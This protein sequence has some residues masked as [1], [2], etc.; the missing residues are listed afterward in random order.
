MTIY[1][2]LCDHEEDARCRLI[3]S[4]SW[5]VRHLPELGISEAAK[6]EELCPADLCGRLLED[7][8]GCEALATNKSTCRACT[9]RFLEAEL[10]KELREE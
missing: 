4:D 10:P 8:R 2:F 3:G 7:D 6:L 1:K 9:R 5:G